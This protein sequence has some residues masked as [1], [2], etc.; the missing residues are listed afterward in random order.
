MNRLYPVTLFAAAIAVWPAMRCAAQFVPITQP[1]AGYLGATTEFTFGDPDFSAISS[2]TASPAAVTFS[3]D[4]IAL[5][6]PATWTSWGSPPDTEGATPRVLWTNGITDVTLTFDTA[7]G[8]VGFEA[9]P[10]VFGVSPMAASVFNGPNFLGQIVLI[11]DG[12]AAQLFAA[13]S[14]TGITSINI[15]SLDDFAVARI[16]AGQPVSAAVPEPR[17][18]IPLG[19]LIGSAYLVLRSNRV[20]RGTIQH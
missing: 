11:V 4:L 7:L 14:S 5:T 8:V 17:S 2:L 16:R 13:T 15:S 12:G 19:C 9:E 6:V 20:R 1:D 18:A 10:N 3:S